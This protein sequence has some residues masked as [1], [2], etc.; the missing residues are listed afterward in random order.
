VSLL[1]CAM[2]GIALGRIR[3]VRRGRDIYHV[4]GELLQEGQQV[5]TAVATCMVARKR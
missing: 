2:T 5:S 4:A 3:M 1:L